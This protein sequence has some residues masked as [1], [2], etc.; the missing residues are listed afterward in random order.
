MAQGSDPLA[1]VGA[2][3]RE[4]ARGISDLE[5]EYERSLRAKEVSET[6]QLRVDAVV[7]NQRS[8]LDYLANRLVEAA[9]GAPAKKV[10]WP[11]QQSEA[12]Y[13]GKLE[14]NVP[15][16]RGARPDVEAAVKARQRWQPGTEW[17]GRL[18][19]LRNPGT[20]IDLLPQTRVESR[21]NE[22][23]GPGGGG[24]SWGPGVTFGS[25]VSVMGAPIDP[26]TQRPAFLPQGVS[27]RETVY[28][29]WLLPDGRSA[30]GS[31]REFQAGLEQLVSELAA[32]AGLKWPA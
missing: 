20:H 32:A 26:G 1:S 9:T 5:A 30:L 19:A 10:Y 22:V 13:E 28:V 3:L 14:Q 2:R 21:G 8:S 16:L 24:V 25:G 27:Y 7:H 11:M 31:L 29:D 18:N 12:E 15:G 6:V 4:A 17:L 23:T